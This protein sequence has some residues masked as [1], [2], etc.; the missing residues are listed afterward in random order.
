MRT[1]HTTHALPSFP[2]YS[3]GFLADDKV[4]LGGGGGA[5]KSGIKNKIRLYT[6]TPDALTLLDELE[7]EPGED[8]PMTMAVN[9]HTSELVCGINSAQEK[10]KA[11]DNQ[12]CRVYGTSGDKIARKQ[13][14]STLTILGEDIDDYQKVTTFS[15]SGELLAVGCTDN[16][17]S[18]LAFPSLSPIAEPFRIPKNGGDVYDIDFYN[19]HVVIA[20]SKAIYIASVPSASGSEKPPVLK[21]LKSI[22]PSSLVAVPAGTTCSFRSARTVTTKEKDDTPSTLLY[23]VVNTTPPRSAAKGAPRSAFVCTYQLTGTGE[24]LLCTLAKSKS[25]SSKAVTVFDI[26]SN[27]Q[28]LGIGSSD[29]SVMILDGKTL[30]PL[31]SIL[32]AHE[33]PPTALRFNASSSLL[34]S[35]SADNSVRVISVPAT[36]GASGATMTTAV[37]VL[38]LSL[39]MAVLAVLVLQQLR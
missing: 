9:N 1:H 28:L 18:V 11:G 25:V 16:Q 7:L 17:I 22:E 35:G 2:V 37:W 34:V 15:P 21:I 20:C 32:N 3:I 36:L 8:A 27:G 19:D 5:S 33:L 38:L 4:A 13:T 31:L 29:L 24:D 26:S 12:N 10:L 30:A 6:V 39:L 23:T 14:T